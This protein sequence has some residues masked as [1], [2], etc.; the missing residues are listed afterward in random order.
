MESPSISSQVL[1]LDLN[2]FMQ[3][4]V[5]L[6]LN[7]CESV[8]GKLVSTGKNLFVEVERRLILVRSD[9]V[10]AIAMKNKG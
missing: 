7:G 3:R 10:Y 4:N 8:E 6:K 5:E 1:R 9:A 2:R